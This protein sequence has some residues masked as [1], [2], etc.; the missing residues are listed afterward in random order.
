MRIVG[1]I[2]ALY[3][4]HGNLPALE[5]V[6]AEVRAAGVDR[7]LVG[8]DVLPGP[9][10]EFVN[11]A[12][13]AAAVAPIFE[14][15]DAPVVVCGHTHVPYD[16]QAGRVRIVNAGSVGM[17][18]SGRGAYW[19]L[20]DGEL[21]ARQTPYDFHAAARRIAATTYPG[22]ADFAASYVLRDSAVN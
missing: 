17:P 15:A 20:I 16:R 14:A 8:G 10:N 6:V 12:T 9:E 18:F 3:D 4:I 13:P 7:L 22:A 21:R 19:L 1:S 2:A 11:A 5:A